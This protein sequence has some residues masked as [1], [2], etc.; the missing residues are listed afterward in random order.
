MS[1]LGMIRL[2]FNPI[3]ERLRWPLIS[4]HLGNY[5]CNNILVLLSLPPSRGNEVTNA[6]EMQANQAGCSYAL[7][8]ILEN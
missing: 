4:P 1:D 8:I 5:A 2:L 3:P 6:G 7:L